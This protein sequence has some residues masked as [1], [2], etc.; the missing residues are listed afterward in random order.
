MASN[1]M[2]KTDMTHFRVLS[3][4]PSIYLEQLFL[5]FT[6]AFAPLILKIWPRAPYNNH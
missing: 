2:N 6:A 5:I 4:S 1:G 3:H